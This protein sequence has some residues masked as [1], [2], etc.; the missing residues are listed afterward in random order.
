MSESWFSR[1]LFRKPDRAGRRR[2]PPPPVPAGAQPRPPTASRTNAFQA[3]GVVPCAQACSA[4]AVVRG[5]RFLA[6]QA[7]RLP[8]FGCDHSASCQC[9]FEKFQ[10]RRHRQ[11]RLPFNNP[12]GLSFGGVEKR[13]DPGRRKTDR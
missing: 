11:Q 5:Q 6:R 10:D 2:A 3:V 12:H 13:R 1:L 9:R 4:A 8:L 7:P